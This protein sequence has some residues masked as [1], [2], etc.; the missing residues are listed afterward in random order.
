VL[1]Y[2]V[3]HALFFGSPLDSTL[4][5]MPTGS[6]FFDPTLP[7]ISSP[8]L[9]SLENVL[10]PASS[11]FDSKAHLFLTLSPATNLD[12]VTNAFTIS[13]ESG[14]IDSEFVADVPESSTWAMMMLG[15]AGLGLVGY[16]TPRRTSTPVAR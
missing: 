5:G 9:N 14:A 12:L 4:A 7:S 2:D 6:P 1:F 13:G 10:D 11:D 3:A 16:L 15:F 8:F